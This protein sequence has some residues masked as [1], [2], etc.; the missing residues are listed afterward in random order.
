MIYACR[1]PPLA[2]EGRRPHCSLH[3]YFP[4]HCIIC[5][6][7]QRRLQH[8]RDL[9]PRSR[10]AFL[11]SDTARL[12]IAHNKQCPPFTS[13]YLRLCMS[14]LFPITCFFLCVVYFRLEKSAWAGVSRRLGFQAMCF[15]TTQAQ[16]TMSSIQTCV[17]RFHAVV[18][19]Y[20][21]IDL[22]PIII[23]MLINMPL[24]ESDCLRFSTKPPTTTN[25]TRTALLFHHITHVDASAPPQQKPPQIKTPRHAL[26]PPSSRRR[27]KKATRHRLPSFLPCTFAF[28]L[29]LRPAPFP[30]RRDTHTHTYCCLTPSMPHSPAELCHVGGG[31]ALQAPRG[32]AEW[33][34][35]CCAVLCCAL[36][37]TAFASQTR[38][39]SWARPTAGAKG[40]MRERGGGGGQERCAACTTYLAALPCHRVRYDGGGL[41]ACFAWLS[42]WL[43][44]LRSLHPRQ[45]AHRT[46]MQR[47]TRRVLCARRHDSLQD[48]WL[49][50]MKHTDHAGSSL[51]GSDRCAEACVLPSLHR[52]A[53]GCCAGVVMRRHRGLR[54]RV[55][56]KTNRRPV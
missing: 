44:I 9:A 53:C 17:L 37:C 24:C 16:T 48:M 33:R 38:Q 15:P 47:I 46:A 35:F 19:I 52:G 39:G 30:L 21:G 40:G 51:S 45:A 10:K 56:G 29:S 13:T 42:A 14:F 23:L 31:G 26:T 41:L 22:V 54:G 43:A 27:R 20:H 18:A 4:S 36:Y 2:T 3:H 28:P 11:A 49:C 8:A 25:T 6:T 7:H 1:L 5:L 32:R 34:R 55:M 50:G 12:R